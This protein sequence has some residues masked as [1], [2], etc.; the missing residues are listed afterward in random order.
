MTDMAPVEDMT[1]HL[2][3]TQAINTNKND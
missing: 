1:Q 3:D 2:E